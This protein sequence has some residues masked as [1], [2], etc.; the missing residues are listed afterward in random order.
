MSSPAK[1]VSFVPL[2]WSSSGTFSPD[3]RWV[4][5]GCVIFIDGF[6]KKSTCR[7]FDAATGRVRCELTTEP[8]LSK[9]LQFSPDGS[10]VVANGHLATMVF[11]AETGVQRWIRQMRMMSSYRSTFSPD[12]GTVYTGSLSEV[13]AFNAATGDRRWTFPHNQHTDTVQDVRLSRDGTRL[14]VASGGGAG[15]DPNSGGFV[16]VLTATQGTELWRFRVEEDRVYRAAFSPDRDKILYYVANYD[17]PKRMGLLDAETGEL[18]GHLPGLAQGSPS[19]FAF[20]PDSR[21]VAVASGRFVH[22]FDVATRTQRYQTLANGLPY[23]D[24]AFSPDAKLFLVG[25]DRPISSTEAVSALDAETGELRWTMSHPHTL[26]TA[27]FSRDGKRVVISG[28]DGVTV[29]E[30]TALAA[31]R[32]RLRH[33]GPVNAV[34]FAEGGGALATGSAD[35]NAR[36]FSV[37]SGTESAHR[38]HQGAVNAVAFTPDGQAVLSGSADGKAILFTTTVPGERFTIDHGVPVHAVAVSRDG[39]WAATGCGD[40]LVSSSARIIKLDTA[41]QRTVGH[42]KPVR[43]VAFTPDAARLA[44]GSDDGMARVFNTVTGGRQLEREH[45]GRVNLVCFGTDPNLLATAS[46]DG[47]ARL[48][49]IRTGDQLR[50]FKHPTAVY[51]V[52]LSLDGTQLAT[53]S[54]TGVRIFDLDTG[55]TRR[56]VSHPAPVRAVVFD[57]TGTLLATAA[58]DGA[59]VYRTAGGELQ[60]ELLEGAPVRAVAFDPAAGLLAV[61]CSDNTARLYELPSD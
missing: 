45:G 60:Y 30:L 34:A 37:T 29:F 43:T 16:R 53:A 48:F 61:A 23:S 14:V 59:R 19:R 54:D 32:H 3:G 22:V 52:A 56:A 10:K 46:D 15:G 36:V 51:G 39:L 55:E 21:L 31:V 18:L 6:G 24:P 7:V 38:T 8:E 41:A 26:Q 35:K 58:D 20:S 28:Y 42:A 1:M 27:E 9:M 12:G 47:T 13:I 50:E 44:T 25:A 5:T 11:D 57:R 17:G 33:D 4:A 40:E 49:D 2:P